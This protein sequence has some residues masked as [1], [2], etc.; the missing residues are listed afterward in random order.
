MPDE[1]GLKKML[2][3][4]CGC[5]GKIKDAPAPLLSASCMNFESSAERERK[6]S[7]MARDK[8]KKEK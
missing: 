1:E 4:F 8:D 5:E 7:K 3:N 2:L 6:I